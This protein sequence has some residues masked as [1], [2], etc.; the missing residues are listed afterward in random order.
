V[1]TPSRSAS[2]R[3]KIRLDHDH[4]GGAHEGCQSRDDHAHGPGATDQNAAAG[5]RVPGSLNGVHRDACRLQ[6]GAGLQG[7]I[8]GEG[9]AD[10]VG[11]GDAF[12]EDP[13]EVHAE[14]LCA[15]AGVGVPGAAGEALAARQVAFQG[16][17]V[18]DAQVL[19]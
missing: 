10:A 17:A 13:V 1:I 19:H 12:G 14:D 9:D 4:V 18:A 5:H 6:Q 11:H 7:H 3:R 2:A 15:L 16:D 8:L